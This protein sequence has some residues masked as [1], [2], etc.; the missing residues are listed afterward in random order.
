MTTISPLSPRSSPGQEWRFR[1]PP[2]QPREITTAAPAANE[3]EHDRSPCLAIAGRPCRHYVRRDLA[4]AAA[5]REY[6]QRFVRA[7]PGKRDGLLYWPSA[8]R[9]VSRVRRS[10]WSL[11]TGTRSCVFDKLWARPRRG[12]GYYRTLTAARACGAG[13]FLCYLAADRM[14]GGFAVVAW[15]AEYGQSGVKT[16]MIGHQ[17]RCSRRISVRP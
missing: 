7:S 5:M 12:T 3:A 9:R 14:I 17:A 11:T 6:A 13:R 4:T 1:T 10:R 15:P 8:V 16:F 2:P